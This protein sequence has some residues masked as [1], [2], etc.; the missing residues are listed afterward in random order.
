MLIKDDTKLKYNEITKD[1]NRVSKYEAYYE[2][3]F[4]MYK[5]SFPVHIGDIPK[6]EKPNTKNTFLQ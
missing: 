2:N 1:G 5:I 6:F 3:D 4:K